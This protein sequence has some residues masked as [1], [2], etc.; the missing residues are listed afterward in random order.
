[1]S[2]DFYQSWIKQRRSAVPPDE[3]PDR[4]MSLV[5]EMQ[6]QQKQVFVV[7]LATWIERSRLARYAACGA[8][9]L[10]GSVPFLAYL[11]YLMVV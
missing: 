9:M 10:V 4:V 3:L 6:M 5:T 11:A 1:M 2:D 8:A 7:R